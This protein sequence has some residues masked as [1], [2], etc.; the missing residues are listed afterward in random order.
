M[1]NSVLLN[2]DISKDK[3]NPDQNTTQASHT[4]SWGPTKERKVFCMGMNHQKT[5]MAI[6]T[7]FGL[8]VYNIPSMKLLHSFEGSSFIMHVHRN[9]V[10]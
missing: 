3:V 1:D 6:G 7:N 2:L 10:C 5:E 8:L 4:K 9:F